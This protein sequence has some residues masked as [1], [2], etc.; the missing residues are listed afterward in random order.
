MANTL[1]IEKE[2]GGYYGFTL[3]I[4][5]VVQDKIRNMFNDAFGKNNLVT[6]NNSTGANLVKKQNISV[7]DITLIASGT[8]TFTDIDDFL[9]KLIDVGFFDWRLGTGGSGGTDRFDELLDTFGYFG[10]DGQAVRVN[11]SQQ[12]LET[13]TVYN[14]RNIT[15]LEDTYDT[16]VPN[17]M[18]VTDNDGNVALED[19]PTLPET[20]LNA[21]GSF[22][23]ADDATQTVPLTVVTDTPLK[24]TNDTL[25]VET[26]ISNAPYG[27]GVVWDETNNQIDLSALSV[28]DLV[29]LR[30]DTELTTGT[31]NQTYRFYANMAI[32]SGNEWTLDLMDSQKKTSGLVHSNAEVSFDIAN[33]DT[34]DFPAEIYV[35]SD[36]G[37]TIVINGWYFEVLRK[38]I[39][40]VE[41]VIDGDET[42]LAILNNLSDLDNFVTAKTNL[43]LE[44]VDNTA[45]IDK[46][47]STPQNTAIDA[48]VSDTAYD[49]SSWNGVTGI[50]PSKNAVRDKIESLAT[51]TKQYNTYFINTAT[52]NNATGVFEDASKPFATIDYVNA[53][54]T[55]TDGTI[56]YLQGTGQTYAINNQL[57]TAS[58]SFIVDDTSTNTLDFSGNN[59]T[60]IAATQSAITYVINITMR[61][62]FVRNNRSGGTG[63]NLNGLASYFTLKLDVREIYW[64]TST[65]M[66]SINSLLP[67]GV[68][69]VPI[70]SCAKILTNFWSEYLH[71]R[72][73]T[74]LSTNAMLLQ[75]QS[76]AHKCNIRIDNINGSGSYLFSTNDNYIIGD[77]STTV[78][79]GFNTT[80]GQESYITFNNSVITGGGIL[81]P[82][83][84]NNLVFSGVIR[85]VTSFTNST[86]TSGI[87]KFVNFTADFGTNKLN[88]N[89]T[90]TISF[91]N[92]SVKSTN[93][94][95]GVVTNVSGGN[96]IIKNSTFE[97]VNAVPLMTG[98]AGGTRTLTIAGV[99]TNATML[100]DQNGTGVTV[101]VIGKNSVADG[102]ESKDAVNKGQLDTAS[103]TSGSFSA[104]GT[105]T[106]TFTVTIGTTQADALYKV[107]ASPS[108]VLSAVMFYINNKTTTTFDVV[109]VTGLTGAVAFDWILK[110]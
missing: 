50:A 28:G 103:G 74:C 10:K 22:H 59:N 81:L 14:Y 37:G 109:F 86:P 61:N 67:R 102:V 34:R 110:P 108:N 27:V 97:V 85:S 75:T 38:N 77:I 3:T 89:G 8:F 46:P 15:D 30:I 76:N 11:E 6:I 101:N 104:T 107:T 45:D 60:N 53:N 23:Y 56:F 79:C 5:G 26:N 51:V 84:A 42:K 47:V 2:T 12:K 17:K 35:V 65:L 87:F 18:L 72:S 43:G 96:F 32:G 40:L 91:E 90:S 25:G 13:F 58:Q 24:L 39:N 73:F 36:G 20:Y 33:E 93:S 95:L 44:N 49:E 29:H 80:W 7:Y 62:G 48:K 68:F 63:V 19:K 94:P 64:N 66:Y 41:I 57:Q 106:T 54:F 4:D 52:G 78:A 82:I 21:V 9:V 69:K 98:G 71:V 83:D 99:S 16:A 92:C 105:A 31:A 88:I 1:L 70:I 55:I 100:S